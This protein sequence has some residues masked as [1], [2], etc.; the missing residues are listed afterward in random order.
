MKEGT[1]G[2]I[3]ILGNTDETLKMG[4]AGE[5]RAENNLLRRATKG[6]CLMENRKGVECVLVCTREE[7][8][9]HDCVVGDGERKRLS[10]DGTNSLMNLL[11]P[12]AFAPPGP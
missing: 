12:L 6:E 3:S 4:S 2:Y 11:F 8:L 10:M 7:S 9:V 5:A 1:R